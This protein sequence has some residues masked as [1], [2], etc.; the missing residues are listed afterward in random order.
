MSVPGHQ[1]AAVLPG[2]G[3][4]AEY[5]ITILAYYRDGARSDPVSL[6][7]APRRWP[8]RHAGLSDCLC[9]A[10]P[11]P[12]LPESLTGSSLS[13]RP[14]GLIAGVLRVSLSPPGRCSWGGRGSKPLM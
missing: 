3:R 13:P 1:A 8:L 11:G 7:Y 6:R 12:Q 10:I 5:E 2:L 4:H 14:S 9:S